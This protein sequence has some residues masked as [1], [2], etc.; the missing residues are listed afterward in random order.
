M[1]FETVIKTRMSVRNFKSD[2]VEDEKLN[3]I[4]EAGRI[5]P[6]AKNLQPQKIYVLTKEESFKKLGKTEGM[7]YGA[8]IMLMICGD[9]EKAWHNN[10][11]D[12]Y[13]TCE[14]DAS[15]VATHMMLEATSLGL[16][17]CWVR[18]FNST[19]LQKAFDLPKNIVPVCLMPIG[20]IA[21]EYK[22][23]PWHYERNNIEDEV[24][25]L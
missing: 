11:Q 13:T 16:G 1:D 20:Y 25:Y 4:L 9:T 7:K 17:S 8:P 14:M 5:A 23:N 6:T 21:E 22:A 10:L 19:E 12:G 15:I 24:I 18:N 3:K 2:K